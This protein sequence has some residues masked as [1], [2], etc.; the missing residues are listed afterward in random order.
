[1]GIEINHSNHSDNHSWQIKNGGRG[2]KLCVCALLIGVNNFKNEF[3]RLDR[4]DRF[5]FPIR[6]NTN[7]WCSAQ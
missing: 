7:F 2:R 3:D 6:F 1:M 4:F 5:Y